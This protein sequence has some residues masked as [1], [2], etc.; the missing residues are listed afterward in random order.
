MKLA[1]WNVNSL[2]VRLQH[3]LDWLQDNPVD[4]L[5]LQELKLPNERFPE[6]QILEAGYHS[7]WSGQKTYN[8]VAILSRA[9]PTNVQRNLPNYQDEQQRVIAADLNNG[10]G[11]SLRVV[12][13]YCPNGQALESEKYAYKLQWFAALH[14]WLQDELDKYPL[15]AIL[16]DYN[17]APADEDVHDP[18]AWEGKNLVSAPER[19]AFSKLLDLGLKD[20][21]RMFAQEPRSFSWWDYRQLGFRRN[22]GLRIDHILA[23]TALA[24][25]C[26]NCHID[27]TPR[28]WT[29]PSDHAPVIADFALG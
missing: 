27:K 23:S 14:A 15:L 28:A 22:A 7:C 5:C 25:T 16:G 29:K 8:G 11:H 19:Q 13:A 18:Q 12:S 6:Q 9:I 20:T 2:N 17:I 3:V 26:A 24:A 1:T 4:A 21:F 10:K